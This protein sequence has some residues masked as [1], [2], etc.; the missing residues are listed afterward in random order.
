M[1]DLNFLE[2]LLRAEWAV[3]SSAPFS[4]C[5]AVLVGWF[6]GWLILRAWYRRSITI[7]EDRL[8]LGEAQRDI[9]KSQKEG[10]RAAL[11]ELKPDASVLAIEIGHG[12]PEIRGV[13]AALGRGETIT[14]PVDPA[15]APVALHIHL[16]D[17]EIKTIAQLSY[18]SAN[19]LSQTIAVGPPV[20]TSGTPSVRLILDDVTIKRNKD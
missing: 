2:R 4:F 3:I 7:G 17:Q 13:V 14:T 1:L 9:E 8:G 10:L 12:D 5:A 19:N 6:L 18:T 20:A 15:T 11:L 16:T